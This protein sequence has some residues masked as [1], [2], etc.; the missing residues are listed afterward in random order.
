MFALN[1][2]H[3]GEN[4]VFFT[5][6]LMWEGLEVGTL[7]DLL[8]NTNIIDKLDIAVFFHFFLIEYAQ[9]YWWWPV[10]IWKKLLLSKPYQKSLFNF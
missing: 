1:E 6:S 10:Y 4:L 5:S 8:A 3:D 2:R 9:K 7:R